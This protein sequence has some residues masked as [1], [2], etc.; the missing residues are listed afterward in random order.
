M[1]DFQQVW[2]GVL[3][4]SSEHQILDL[5]SS[6]FLRVSVVVSGV[7]HAGGGGLLSSGIAP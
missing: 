5:A 2:S 1:A 3:T 6:L 4:C 7:N